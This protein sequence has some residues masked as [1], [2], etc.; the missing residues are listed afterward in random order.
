M[1]SRRHERHRPGGSGEICPQGDKKPPDGPS[2]LVHRTVPLSTRLSALIH[3]VAD[4]LN[5][6]LITFLVMNPEMDVVIGVVVLRSMLF[7]LATA[8]TPTKTPQA[9]PAPVAAPVPCPVSVQA[10]APGPAPPVPTTPPTRHEYVA[11]SNIFMDRPSPRGRAAID[12]YLDD[13]TNV[14]YVCQAA[15]SEIN[16]TPS[17]LARV[18]GV[19]GGAQI[20]Q[21]ANPSLAGINVAALVSAS[22]DVNDMEI[23]ETAR[24]RGL[25]LLT[26]NEAMQRQVYSNVARRAIWGGVD[27]RV[28]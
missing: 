26:A 4:V 22:F 6:A 5:M 13:P 2:A 12:P 25:P 17:Q 20:I 21:V 28:L 7:I 8:H 14:V 23:L 11:D 3:T 18:A 1:P 9:Q 15:V 27:I 19:P 24:Q 10:Q 16:P